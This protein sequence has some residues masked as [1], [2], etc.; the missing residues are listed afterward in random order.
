[1]IQHNQRENQQDNQN[2]FLPKFIGKYR[3]NMTNLTGF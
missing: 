1:M 2:I 3:N